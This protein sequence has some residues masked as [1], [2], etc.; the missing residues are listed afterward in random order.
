MWGRG[1]TTVSGGFEVKIL[2]AEDD[3][4]SRKIMAKMLSKYGQ[5]DVTEDGQLAVNAFQEA[6]GDGKPYQLIFLDIMM[7]NMDGKE[8]L[9]RIRALE[10]DSGVEG[11]QRSTIFMLTALSDSRSVKEAFELQCDGYIV[12]PVD[13]KKLEHQLSAIGAW[14]SV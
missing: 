4:V 13:R 8:A 5:C 2:V 1:G 6:L 11:N 12:K 7:P 10:G 9:C 14:A 3:P